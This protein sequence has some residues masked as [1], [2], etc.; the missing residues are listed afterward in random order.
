MAFSQCFQHSC[1]ISPIVQ[2][3]LHWR[4]LIKT[5]IFWL[6]KQI[7]TP[8]MFRTFLWKCPWWSLV[9]TNSQGNINEAGLQHWHFS[10]LFFFFF[11]EN[12]ACRVHGIVFFW[13]SDV[14]L[15]FDRNL[16][17]MA[18]QNLLLTETR[19]NNCLEF[20]SEKNA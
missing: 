17:C 2:R 14:F 3:Q 16:Y 6:T 1:S 15:V 5:I 12:A 9:F 7:K 10:W 20:P 4:S 11:S 13:P 19:R 8:K 18:F